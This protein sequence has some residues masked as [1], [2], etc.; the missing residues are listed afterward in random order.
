MVKWL[1]EGSLFGVGD[2]QKS[3]GGFPPI[4]RLRAARLR[5]W[6]Y[7]IPSRSGNPEMSR[8]LEGS[9]GKYV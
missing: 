8:K 4:E 7:K 2:A 1:R 3:V 9:H 5:S 6:P